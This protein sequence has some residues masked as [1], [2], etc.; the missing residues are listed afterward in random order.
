MKLQNCALRRWVARATL[1]CTMVGLVS[2]ASAQS[3]SKPAADKAA[4]PA[5]STQLP[6][7]GPKPAAEPGTP[8]GPRGLANDSCSTPQ[9][10]SGVGP[11]VFNSNNATTG[12]EGQGFF[13]GA[14]GSVPGI[15]ND[16]WFC[17]TADCTGTVTISTCGQTQADTR[18]AIYLGCACPLTPANPLCCNDDGCGV[19]SLL[20]CDV[21]CG[22]QYM[23]QIG[24]SPGRP[25]GS[26]TFTVDC[27]GSP[28]GGQHEGPLPE[29]CGAKPTYR[30][31]AYSTFTGQVMI[32][33]AETSYPPASSLYALTVFDIKDHLT[34]PLDVNWN[35]ANL[36][37][38]NPLWTKVNLGSLFGVTLDDS[39]NIYAA[40]GTLYNSSDPIGALAGSTAGSIYKI[41][42]NT[43]TP[44]VFANL[45]NNGPGIGNVS[46]DCGHNQIFAS[47][48]EDGRI[49]RISA[50]GAMLSAYD[51]A[52]GVITP[53]VAGVIANEAGEPNGQ[54]VPR[55]ERVW[56]VRRQGNRVYYSLWNR[57]STNINDTTSPL[58]P[59]QI[60]SIQLN[61]SGEFVAG[62]A[63]LEK[64]IPGHGTEIYSEPVSDISFSQSTPAKMLLAERNM[65]SDTTSY[66][67]DARLLELQFVAG[68]WVA[69][70]G[71]SNVNGP[72]YG[73]SVGDYGDNTN[74]AGG[75][76]YDA[77]PSGRIWCSGD[78]LQFGPGFIY[79]VTGVLP[80]GSSPSNGILIDYNND[81]T[82]GDKTQLGDVVIPCSR[83]SCVAFSNV[84]IRCNV[85]A[86]GLPTGTYTV[87]YTFTNNSGVPIH[88]VLLPNAPTTPHVIHL[89]NPVPV[90]GSATVSVTLT[91]VVPNTNYCFHMIFADSL[92]REC[93]NAQLCVDIPPCDCIQVDHVG[94]VCDPATGSYVLNFSFQ[95]LS[96][97]T[98]SY[99]FIAPSGAA[100]ANPDFVPLPN[101]PPGG[102]FNMPPVTLG[103]VNP[104]DHI[105]LL[106]S[107]HNGQFEEC[108]SVI[109][110]VDIPP[111]CTI[112]PCI[113][114]FN[115]DGVVNSQDYFDFLVAFFNN[116][117]AAD[118]NH[119]GTV[120]SQDYFDF[121][122][123][124]FTGC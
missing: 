116:N 45:P 36:R 75:A 54:F 6:Q 67:H 3:V 4:K 15:Q 112:N 27:A 66:A 65:T 20:R 57:D 13:C 101:I 22:Q 79:G 61:A 10:I 23:I 11:F 5:S 47:N 100:T 73:F 111:P 78:A 104:G 55:G 76:D 38:N 7:S 44:T 95:N 113:A 109:V 33:T 31:A 85:G 74:S 92:I 77:D 8:V 82:G 50:T 29:C 14:A 70:P 26:G 52:T 119:S 83:A 34:A 81:I 30:D 88:Y 19:Q 122:V 86:D 2:A 62:T 105:C 58:P 48:L 123:A 102:I 1:G 71:N 96:T 21:T 115:H 117:I 39:G 69:S 42:N 12:A 28:C 124:F 114:D 120:N 87:T 43:G 118:F 94:V 99:L 108:C 90:G 53:A 93:C 121:L 110:C 25:P 9:S 107:V 84:T 35:P 18:I 59:N 49:Y 24:S 80:L 106:I 32:M 51:H 97:Q 98:L 68:S 72:S 63:V 60:W 91:G 16:E 89:A 56:A 17:W 103:N 41:A 46:W 40:H 37:Y 64:N